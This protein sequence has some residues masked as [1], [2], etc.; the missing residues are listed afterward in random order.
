MVMILYSTKVDATFLFVLFFVKQKSKNILI[1]LD[2][3]WVAIYS[4]IRTTEKSKDVLFVKI[5]L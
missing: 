2:Y 3:S 5:W 4:Y 1:S